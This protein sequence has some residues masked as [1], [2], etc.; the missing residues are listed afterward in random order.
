M[1]AGLSAPKTELFKRLI[2]SSIRLSI[3]LILLFWILSLGAVAAPI[4]R[5]ICLDFE[6]L[7]AFDITVNFSNNLDIAKI[8]NHVVRVSLLGFCSEYEFLSL[9]FFHLFFHFLF[10]FNFFVR[11]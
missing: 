11:I 4:P 2:L 6:R 1:R 5:T 10:D 9:L 8:A 7:R 3:R